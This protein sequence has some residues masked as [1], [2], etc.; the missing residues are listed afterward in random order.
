MLADNLSIP[1]VT[2]YLDGVLQVTRYPVVWSN[3]AKYTDPED[4]DLTVTVGGGS[5]NGVPFGDL[6][7]ADS[8]TMEL[9]DYAW[10]V[11]PGNSASFEASL[12]PVPEEV[13]F[14]IDK[15]G[16]GDIRDWYGLF[17]IG[18]TFWSAMT[19]APDPGSETGQGLVRSE[20]DITT[21][22]TYG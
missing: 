7:G 20:I 12:D 10:P 3:T 11:L 21:A 16:V 5:I 1:V 22:L 18:V 17:S 13:P 9:L 2:N 15:G 6:A 19:A 14:W 8:G 4:D